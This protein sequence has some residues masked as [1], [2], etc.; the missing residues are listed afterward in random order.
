MSAGTRPGFDTSPQ[1]RTP[2]SIDV[3]LVEDEPLNLVLFETILD[4]AGYSVVSA[5]D[6]DEAIGYLRNGVR[7][8][9]VVSD[10]RMPG[11]TDGFGVVKVARE[12]DPN[13]PVLLISGYFHVQE[14][15]LLGDLQILLKPFD[16]VQLLA[17]VTGLPPIEFLFVGGLLACQRCVERLDEI[18]ALQF[19]GGLAGIELHR[20][21]QHRL[22]DGVRRLFVVGGHIV[23][24]RLVARQKVEHLF[25]NRPR[26]GQLGFGFLD[27]VEHLAL[28]FI[29]FLAELRLAGQH[30]HRDL[31]ARVRPVGAGNDAR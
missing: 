28:F 21:V 15:V 10:I 6:G 27:T 25:G 31:F 23:Q 3:L 29:E 1:M 18:G 12:N 7:P 30:L 13:V 22:D 24:A 9:L 4:D 26:I 20:E 11:A 16:E 14:A 17:A 2:A 19:V 5:A 8:R